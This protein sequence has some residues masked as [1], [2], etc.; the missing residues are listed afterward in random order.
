MLFVITILIV[1]VI[2]LYV[3]SQKGK[4]I[5]K[6][7]KNYKRV[8][9]VKWNFPIV[10]HGI[11]FSRDI[12]G[13][14]K[15]C[16]EE[17]G[18]VFQIK[19]FK[20]NICI[21][22]NKSMVKEFFS[23][24]EHEMSM[25]GNLESI[26][27]DYAFS[28][29][30]T[31]LHQ[32]IDVMNSTIKVKFDEFLP[33]MLDEAEKMISKM[34]NDGIK[35]D[36]LLTNLT[37]EFVARTSARCFL[38]LSMTPEIYKS[39]QKF[40]ALLNIVTTMTYFFP[41]IMIRYTI[42]LLFNKYRKDFGA[43]IKPYIKDYRQN[44]DLK[45]SIIMRHCV[46]QKLSDDETCDAIICLMYVSSENTA[47]GLNATLIDLIQNPIYLEKIRA[48]IFNNKFDKKTM[49][50][51]QSNLLHACVLESARLN[52]HVFAITRN[53]FKNSV[54]GEYYLG[55]TDRVALCE[56]LLMSCETAAET[57]EDP[58]KY[59][60]DR[61]LKD[62]NLIK[63]DN[64]ITW[65]S[66][67]H[68]CPGKLFAIY[69][70]KTAVISIL[71]KYD[72]YAK[73][74]PP[75]NYFSPSAYADRTDIKINVKE[76]TTLYENIIVQQI[77]EATLLRNYFS[78]KEQQEIYD[79]IFEVSAGA[80]EHIDIL[81]EPTSRA[82]PILMW[83]N[84]YTG[85]SNCTEPTNLLGIG[86][87]ILKQVPLMN[88]HS[89]KIRIQNV[90]SAYAQLFGADS[91]MSE[92]YDQ[93]VDWG[94]SLNLGASIVFTFGK[95]LLGNKRHVVLNS[96]DVF[97]GN[98]AR[99]LHGVLKILPN[100]PEWFMNSKNYGRTRCSI[101]LRDVAGLTNE[102]MSDKAFKDLLKSY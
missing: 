98:F 87:K 64:I 25:Y 71:S 42:G 56:P 16:R 32:V 63:P 39:L 49:I 57:F 14:I 35:D 19:I 101:Q 88:K 59:N 37:I 67:I 70:I 84:A 2:G 10:G 24:K 33:K 27:F 95:D 93:Y 58:T 40:T 52:S 76:T 17:Y 89:P 55:D 30:G 11:S 1:L 36:Q 61:Y 44:S 50:Q 99:H 73:S 51:S 4:K 75:L 100:T 97:V 68:L 65:G 102:K 94:I 96:G 26:Y 23:K 72:V 15:K 53:T 41:K 46:D 78:E 7:F 6:E 79:K 60:P 9:M 48:E 18:D 69:E 28:D 62:R 8:P 81:S 31:K 3:Y 43:L 92:H 5:P 83:N 13:F 21:I 91:H 77:G 90:N 38:G 22:C 54:L 29:D 12:I 20:K 85:E 47:L 82:F 74:I 86:N 66:G 34:S 45:E 80:K